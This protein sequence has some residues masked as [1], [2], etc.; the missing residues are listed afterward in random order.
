MRYLDPQYIGVTYFIL[1]IVSSY[2]LV[3]ASLYHLTYP[4]DESEA[5][6]IVSSEQGLKNEVDAPRGDEIQ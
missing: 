4:F 2:I 6:R 5:L 1:T 3:I